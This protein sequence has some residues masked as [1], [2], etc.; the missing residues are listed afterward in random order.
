MTA[1]FTRRSGL[2]LSASLAGGLPSVA[3]SPGATAAAGEPLDDLLR[4]YLGRFG[5]PAAGAAVLRGGQVVA[6]GAVGTRRVGTDNPVTVHDR[7]HIGS[8]GK[9]MTVLIA[10]QF[11]QQGRLRWDTRLEEVYPELTATMDAGLRTVT[12]TQIMSHTSGLPADTPAIDDLLGQAM[13]QADINLDAMRHWVVQQWAPKPL[14][15]RPGE[16]WAYSNLG[17]LILGA[18]LERVSGRTWEELMVSH[19]F[20]PLQLR[21]AGFGPQSS[22]GRVDAPL[23]HRLVDGKPVALLAGPNGDNPAIL[24]PA[25]T[26]H[27]SL[28]DFAAWANWQVGEGRRGPALVP[29][30]IMRKMHARVADMPVQKDAA[31]GTPGSVKASDMGYGLGWGLLTLSY[32]KDPFLFHGGSNGLNYALIML[33]P[34]HDFAMVMVTNIGGPAGDEAFRALGTELYGKYMKA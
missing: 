8:D 4:P 22:L 14:V 25:G 31:T 10:A 11:I 23:G 17:Y 19:V 16:A 21:S 9:A 7:F 2:G 29:P 26:A 12:L 28:M 13:Q 33:Q 3:R 1:H 34:R 18:V 24:G 6:S 27:L 32:A 30:A 15:T 20:D 5:L